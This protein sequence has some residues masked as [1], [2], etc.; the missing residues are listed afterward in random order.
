MPPQGSVYVKRLRESG[1]KGKIFG[2]IQMG[3][4]A[5]LRSS[6]GALEGAWFPAGDD[7][8]AEK[9]YADYRKKF[10][11]S[12]TAEAL[13]AYDMLHILLLGLKSGDPVNY[14]HTVKNFSGYSGT[15]SADGQ[16][17]FTF[18]TV[19]KQFTAD[20]FTYPEN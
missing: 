6:A 11:E 18:K 13:Y 7:R 5:E 4:L 1:F 9:Y 3:N 19:P 10:A 14:M 16:N 12:S 20:G 8:G 2:G 17:G 15:F